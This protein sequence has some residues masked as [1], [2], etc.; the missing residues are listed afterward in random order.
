LRYFFVVFFA[1]AFAAGF[2]AVVFLAGFFAAGI[3]SLPLLINNSLYYFF[4]K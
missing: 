1:V 2:F 4:V 3:I